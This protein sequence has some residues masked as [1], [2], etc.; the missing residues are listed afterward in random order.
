MNASYPARRVFYA[1][2][3]PAKEQ[4]R[5]FT[6]IPGTEPPFYKLTTAVLSGPLTG[7]SER[8]DHF[9]TDVPNTFI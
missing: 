4:F 7:V 8:R 6:E 9:G 3:T 1:K 2:K 5:R